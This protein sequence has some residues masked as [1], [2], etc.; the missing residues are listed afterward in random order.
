LIDLHDSFESDIAKQAVVR[1]IID[2]KLAT[3]ENEVRMLRRE[4]VSAITKIDG[5][6]G[7]NGT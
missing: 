3:L 1:K 2:D 5:W 4:R 6:Y 7:S